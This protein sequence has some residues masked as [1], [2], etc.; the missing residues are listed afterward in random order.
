MYKRF[1]K[2]ELFINRELQLLQTELRLN[3]LQHKAVGIR[4]VLPLL[5]QRSFKYWWLP[6]QIITTTTTTTIFSIFGNYMKED[7]CTFTDFLILNVQE[8]ND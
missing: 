5:F 6:L 7:Y 3:M 1:Y 4:L 2:A 8:V